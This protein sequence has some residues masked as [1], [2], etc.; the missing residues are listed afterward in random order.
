MPL[1]LCRGPIRISLSC[2]FLVI[3]A[4]SH[5]KKVFH[6]FIIVKS[7]SG[8]RSLLA[9]MKQILRN[10]FHLRIWRC[11]GLLS[12][13]VGKNIHGHETGIEGH[14]ALKIRHFFSSIL[15]FIK[16]RTYAV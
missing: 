3:V 9:N 11:I 7:L 6:E 13:R 8:P 4:F 10:H 2:W 5:F 16:R 15:P 14:D 12:S 1:G